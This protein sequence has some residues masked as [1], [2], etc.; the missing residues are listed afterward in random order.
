MKVETEETRKKYR[1]LICHLKYWYMLQHI[2]EQ[3]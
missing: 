3:K 1:K 2:Y